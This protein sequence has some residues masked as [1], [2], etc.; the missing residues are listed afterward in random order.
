MPEERINRHAETDAE[1]TES[2][3]SAIQGES[4]TDNVEQTGQNIDPVLQETEET[5]DQLLRLGA[6]FENY[7]KRME[8]EREALVKYAGEQVLREL[9]AT[10]DNLDRAIEQGTGESEDVQKKLDAMLEGVDLTRKG[11][12]S[13]LEKFEVTPIESVGKPFDPN[14]Q[15]ALTME[16]SK[17]MPPNHVLREFARGYRFRDRLLRP[18]KVVVSAG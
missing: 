4:T 6:E 16:P 15:E 17:E 3:D 12:L 7:K 2:P 5:R 1:S 9:L 10:L 18:A 14:E 13:T 8:R 11:L